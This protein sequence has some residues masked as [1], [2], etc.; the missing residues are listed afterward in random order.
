VTTILRQVRLL[1]QI[2]SEFS[3]FAGQPTPR[4]GA[5]SLD[6]LLEEVTRP[7]RVGLGLQTTIAVDV[8]PALPAVYVDRTLIARAFTNLVENAVQAMPNGGTLD[9]TAGERDG[10]VA[11]TFADSGVGMDADAAARAFEPYF[12]TKTAGSGLGLANAR[13]NIEICGGTIALTSTIGR[14]TSVIVTLP[15]TP[16]DADREAGSTPVQ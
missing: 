9:V 13:R 8:P 7:Y 3:T 2:A 5:V 14:G 10:R 1:R 4:F 15:V 6:G 16:L 11:V 12:S